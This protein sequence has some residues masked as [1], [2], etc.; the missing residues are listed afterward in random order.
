MELSFTQR[1]LDSLIFL[2]ESDLCEDL[3]RMLPQDFRQ[4]CLHEVGVA[5]L[6]MAAFLK[7]DPVLFVCHS[8]FL[9]FRP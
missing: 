7:T 3:F 8:L 9:P 1:R 6:N 4:E 5:N 2:T